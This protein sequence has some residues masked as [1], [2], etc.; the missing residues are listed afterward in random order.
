[1]LKA[2][3]GRLRNSVCMSRPLP[4][5]MEPHMATLTDNVKSTL[6]DHIKS[7]ESLH[8]RIAA[9]PGIDKTKLQGV[10]SEYKAAAQKFHDDALGCMN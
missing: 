3:S 1:M 9:T 6:D 10:F 7:I 4:A 2:P 8:Q 5:E